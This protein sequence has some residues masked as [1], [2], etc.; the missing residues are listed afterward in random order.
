MRN[1]C[2]VIISYNPGDYLISNVIALRPQVDNVI[3]VDNGSREYLRNI[4]DT[5]SK[6]GGV[7]VIY[8]KDNLGIAAALNIGIKYAMN[9][10]YNWVATFD[11]DSKAK[12]EFIN[13]MLSA[14]ESCEYKDSVA[15]IS[16]IYYDQV[17]GKYCSFGRGKANPAS[18][19]KVETTMTSGNLI[20]T[21]IFP[22][23][24]LFDEAFF[25]DYVDYEFCF[26]CL[27][28]GFKIIES[29]TSVLYHKVGEPTQHRFLWKNISATNHSPLRW[30]YITRNRI[31]LWKRYF[32]VKPGWVMRDIIG[33]VKQI[34]KIV[35]Y[36]NDIAKKVFSII[37]GIYHGFSGKLGKYA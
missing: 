29:Q 9:A 10:G 16:P 23:V 12:T 2:A 6:I 28:H 34:L 27:A 17:T 20:P 22:K 13:S 37:K 7:K 8:N 19:I 21:Y 30:Y 24:G 31:V 35:L 25:I 15:I 5:V 18:F 14:Y 26:R 33:L 36:E 32:L 1:V 3:I 11:Q 4:L